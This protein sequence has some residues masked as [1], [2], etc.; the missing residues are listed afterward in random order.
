MSYIR[1][2]LSSY[3]KVDLRTLGIFRF[4]FGLVC[5]IDIYRRL[6]YIE[7]FYSDIGITPLSLTS[8]NSFSLLSY[9]D[10]GS[11]AMVSMFFYTAL[12][13]SFL[14]MVGYKTKFSQIVMTLALLS[15]HNRLIIV[16]NGGDFV[17]NAFLIWSVFLPLGKRF[18]LD[19]LLY[20]L[21]HYRDSTPFSL[22]SG[23]LLTSDEPK[24]YWGIAYFACI[25]QLSIIYF[26]N[27]V[28]KSVGTWNDGSSLYY[29]YQL[30]IF[31]TP[32][33]NFIKE[34]SLM[35]MWLSEILTQ[36][37]LYLELW[38]PFLLIIP[39]FTLWIRRFSMASMIGFHIIIGATMYIGMFSW[40]MIS[41]LL[42]LLSARDIDLL[43]KYLSR[44]S[45][46]S[47]IA[48]YDSD[49]GFCHQSARI[50]RRMDLFSS[51]TWAGKDWR[52]E[53][54]EELDSLRD[55]TIVIWDKQNNKVYTRHKAFSKIISSLPFG[56]LF[57]WI[58]LVP[59][60]S[61]LA[62]YIYDL[63]SRKRTSISKLLGYSACDISEDHSENQFT[64]I[65]REHRFYRK[66]IIATE[67]LKSIL[68]SLLLVG[69]VNYAF[70]KCYQKTKNSQFKETVKEINFLKSFKSS[71]YAY[72]FI[73]KTRMIQN[74]NMFYSVPK[75]YKWMILEARTGDKNNIYDAGERFI[76]RGNGVY[77]LGESFVDIGNGA[78]D[79]GEEFTD[80]KDIQV[81]HSD[82]I[83]K[84]V[85]KDGV[86][87]LDI[88]GGL[89]VGNGVYDD[90]EAFIDIGNG[91]Y[92]KGEEFT[93]IGNGVY[94]EGETF[95]DITPIV[96]FFTG[97]SPN[98]ND[99]NYDT[100]KL[101]DN[102]QFWRKFIYR[103]NPYNKN[104][105]TYHRYRKRFIELA[106]QEDNPIMPSRD[107]NQDGR[108]DDADQIQS[109]SLISIDYSVGRQRVSKRDISEWTDK[110]RIKPRK[111]IT[112]KK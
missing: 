22:N 3:L 14:F 44:L 43:K 58:F 11:V 53:K 46:G 51:I 26:F 74:W 52:D 62:G 78:W 111:K 93:D 23:P 84:S 91:V 107:F 16:E 103:I 56:F 109:I 36:M 108:I 7:V 1:Y 12:L 45:P 90:G 86:N 15:I 18:S 21:K 64:P 13:F 94:D 75:S 61:H 71:S 37:T 76:D 88:I 79:P 4:I 50:I 95:V 67:S 54:P 25:L 70:A 33:G 2:I 97:K 34:F 72:K 20:S 73:R 6:K 17:M 41:A 59:G 24:N 57:A 47:L 40:V 106:M 83:S 39:I 8:T 110:K 35:P 29:F 77:D 69:T 42:L 32:M 102:S 27:F 98:Y 99:L 31:L 96:D 81:T 80:K 68:V 82:S 49:C 10:I 112:K 104:G 63:I 28:N 48:F 92:D 30:D 100:F 87:V 89:K 5:F 66:F 105:D 38:V 19:R 60:L 65:Y 101:I 55:S 9:F 85:F